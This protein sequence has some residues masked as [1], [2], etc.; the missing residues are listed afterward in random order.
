MARSQCAGCGAVFASL[1][2]FDAH[3]TGV[4]EQRGKDGRLLRRAS[5]RCRTFVELLARGMQ[6]NARGWWTSGGKLPAHVFERVSA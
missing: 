1:S 6:Q 4:Y 2:A 3:R 5:R